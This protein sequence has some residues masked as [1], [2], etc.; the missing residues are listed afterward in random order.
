MTLYAFYGRVSTEDQ[1]DPASSRQWQ[2]ARAETLIEPH[3]GRIV[4]EY[5][6][7]G[8]SR[9]LPWKRRP[10]A[11]RLLEGFKDPDRGFDAVVVGEPARAFYGNQF[12]LTF[13]VFVHYGLEL[14]VPEVG[15]KVDPGSD[16]HDLVMS[17]YG[18]MSKGERNRIKIRVRAAMAAQAQTE[19]R[20]LGGRPPYGYRLADAGAHPN[21]GKAAIGQRLHRLEPDPIAAPI[22]RRIFAEYLSGKGFYAIAEGLTRDGLPSPSSHDVA[23]NRHRDGRAWAKSAVRA[24][25]MNPRYTGH[26]VWNRQR[27]DEVPLD[28]EDVAAGYETKL[29]WN[30]RSAWIWSGHPTH[31]ALLSSED[32]ARVQHEMGASAHRPTPKKG[33]SSARFYP[34]SG[35]VRCSACGRRM[36]G[37]WNHEMAHYRCRFPYEYAL[38]NK[39]DHPL[40]VYVKESAILPRLDTWLAELFDEDNLDATCDALAMSADTDEATEARREAARRK[41]ADCDSRLAKY[42]QALDAGADAA[43]VAGWMAEVQG[44][45]LRAERDL[46]AVT[47]D[48]KL[49]KEQIQRLVIQL[50]DIASVLAMAD[51]KDKAEIYAELGVRVNYAPHRRVIGVSAGSCTTAR[52]GGGT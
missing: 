41:L 8:Q 2:L 52:V 37:T 20:F 1:Q 51:P 28:I 23:R 26:Q 14:W 40:A 32:F 35:L 10:E 43:V 30:D 17:L 15:G 19:G 49:S 21:P 44:E 27:R 5:F 11:A 12:G 4:A 36:Q 48:G 16:A 3:G 45:R 33:H 50:R 22:V 9:S 31:E 46:G 7:I 25:L 18:G 29:R 39:V 38:A 13:P 6:D 34:L 42:R 47:P 24:I